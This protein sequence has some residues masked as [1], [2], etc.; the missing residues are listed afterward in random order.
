M[1]CETP[2]AQKGEDIFYNFS[3]N[4]KVRAFVFDLTPRL[5]SFGGVQS[6]SETDRIL[7]KIRKIPPSRLRLCISAHVL[8]VVRRL[9]PHAPPCER[10]RPGE[11]WFAHT[12]PPNIL[13]ALGN[14]THLT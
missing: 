8:R 4:A 3:K 7:R 14:L 9:P 2:L 5:T 1:L 10:A 13:V 12:P 11:P 6:L